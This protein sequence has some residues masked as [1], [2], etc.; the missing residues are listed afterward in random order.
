MWTTAELQ[1]RPGFSEN[2]RLWTI[3]AG[4]EKRQNRKCRDNRRFWN[5]WLLSLRFLFFGHQICGPQFQKRPIDDHSVSSQMLRWA[6][7]Q[8][9]CWDEQHARSI[10][11]MCTDQIWLIRNDWLWQNNDGKRKY[12]LDNDRIRDIIKLQDMTDFEQVRR[13]LNKLCLL[14]T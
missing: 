2:V 8:V 1:K 6:V 4:L 7:C 5:K 10:D 3:T 11:E 14:L 9:K 12:V 13:C